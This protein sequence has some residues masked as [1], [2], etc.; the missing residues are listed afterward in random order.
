MNVTPP[1]SAG[2][3]TASNRPRGK[4][5]PAVPTPPN[6]AGDRPNNGSGHNTKMASPVNRPAQITRGT[7]NQGNNHNLNK[8]AMPTGQADGGGMMGTRGAL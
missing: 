4:S 7:G 1:N 6:A 5:M 8:G 3:R 2:N